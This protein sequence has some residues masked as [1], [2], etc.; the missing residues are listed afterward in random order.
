[1]FPTTLDDPR[2]LDNV[3]AAYTYANASLLN[4]LLTKNY[5]YDSI[6]LPQTLL[7]P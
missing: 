4:L 7:L 3:N 2:F 6:P 5:S 1:M